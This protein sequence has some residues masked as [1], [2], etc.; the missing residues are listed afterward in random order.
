MSEVDEDELNDWLANEDVMAFSASVTITEWRGKAPKK[1]SLS[2]C[3]KTG[4]GHDSPYSDDPPDGSVIET[5][6]RNGYQIDVEGVMFYN[7]FVCPEC[8]LVEGS[9]CR[10]SKDGVLRHRCGSEVTEQVQGAKWIRRT[11]E[12]TLKGKV[13]EEKI[14]DALRYEIAKISGNYQELGLSLKVPKGMSYRSATLIYDQEDLVLLNWLV[15]KCGRPRR[16]EA[17]WYDRLVW[18]YRGPAAYIDDPH[19]GSRPKPKRYL[20]SAGERIVSVSPKRWNIEVLSE[21]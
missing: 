10:T 9:E 1:L 20:F 16:V 14:K 3:Y 13:N 12:L 5:L 19:G 7:K 17:K 18:T 6:S 21:G 8:G 2:L 4:D 11:K 15:R